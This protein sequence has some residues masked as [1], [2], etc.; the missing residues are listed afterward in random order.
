MPEAIQAMWKEN[1]NI[2]VELR[3]EEWKVFQTTRNQKKIM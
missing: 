3:N 1:L 2:N